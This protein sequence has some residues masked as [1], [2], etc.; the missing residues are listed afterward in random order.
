MTT[1]TQETNE[2]FERLQPQALL[3]YQKYILSRTRH[4]LHALMLP[5]VEADPS[6]PASNQAVVTQGDS[7]NVRMWDGSTVPGPAT[8]TGGALTLVTPAVVATKA[9]VANNGNVVV[10]DLADAAVAGSPGRAT[11]AAGALTKVNLT[12]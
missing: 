8:V 7:I 11:V 2:L 6:P 5:L 12:V 1:P 10:H 4:D 3:E 9:I